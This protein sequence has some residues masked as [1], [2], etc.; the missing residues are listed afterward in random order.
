MRG[1]HRVTAV[2]VV[3]FNPI[4]QFEASL[5]YKPYLGRERKGAGTEECA[6]T[7]CPSSA[8]VLHRQS[9][10]TW[11]WDPHKHTAIRH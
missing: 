5:D 2:V 10:I 7:G 1:R 6:L 3:A 8:S 11:D 4:T 9:A